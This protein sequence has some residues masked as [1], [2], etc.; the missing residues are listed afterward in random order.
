MQDQKNIIDCY[1]KT[2]SNYA[3]KF[4][5]E[6][7]HKHLDK[8]LL[9]AFAAQNAGKGKLIDL[10][11]GPGQTTKFLADQGLSK[12][13][14]TDL[15][16]EM[17]SVARK[18]FPGIDFETADMLN[19]HYPDSSFGSAIA[20]YAV[21]HFDYEQMAIAFREIS[22]IL[23]NR[24]EFLFSF[25]IGDQTVHLD[26]FLE[27]EVDI[28]FYFF[29]S[30]RIRDVLETAGFEIIDLIERAP[31]PEVEYPS[32]RAYIWVRKPA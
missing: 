6:L 2:A 10:G 21:V 9:S 28:D 16:P 23:V 3:A 29:D 32:T 1:N 7:S 30:A 14:G 20:F 8:I 17:I 26:D 24:G 18:M 15:S 12:L 22:R 13:L 31:Y 5:D 25:H 4:G 19:L 27:K 11:C